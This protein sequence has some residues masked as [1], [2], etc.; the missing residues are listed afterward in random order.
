MKNEKVK[1]ILKIAGDVLLYV[2]IGISLVAMVATVIFKQNNDD[3]MSI[4]GMQMRLV[5]TGSMEK[6]EYTDVSNY[7]IKSIPLNSMVFIENVPNDK[8]AAKEWYSELQVG[9]VLTFKYVYQAGRQIVIT[10]RIV[11]IVENN[12]KDGYLITLEGDN[13][14]GELTGQQVINTSPTT[15]DDSFNYVIGKVTGQSYLLGLLLTFLK[16][17]FGLILVIVASIIIIGYEIFKL[18][19]MANAEKREKEQAEKDARDS[20]LDELRRKLAALEA[21]SEA[22]PTEPSKPTT[23]GE[24]ADSDESAAEA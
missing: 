24:V 4:F 3:A 1:K 5:I 7:K 8:A 13:K 18:I 16:S 22:S 19:R 10:H 17:P 20:E 2:F 14:S 9:D 11:S 12:A 15:V 23:E 21:Q 6:S